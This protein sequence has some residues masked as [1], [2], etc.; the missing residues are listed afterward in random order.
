MK[1]GVENNQ[2]SYSH[3]C[4]PKQGYVL[5]SLM[6]LNG[7][8]VDQFSFSLTL[9]E[10]GRTSLL[11]ERLQVHG[12]WRKMENGNWVGFIFANLFDWVVFVMW[13]R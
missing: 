12:L 4:D 13:V 1:N 7:M 2:T 8:L 9:K 3:G 6:I 11:N 10:C 5:F